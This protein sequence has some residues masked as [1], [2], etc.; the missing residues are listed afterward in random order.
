M[1]VFFY[2][3]KT[4]QQLSSS[5]GEKLFRLQIKDCICFCRNLWKNKSKSQKHYLMFSFFFSSKAIYS[6][7]Y[8]AIYKIIQFNGSEGNFLQVHIRN[9]GQL[10]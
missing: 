5:N 7:E 4:Q 6:L 8:S 9:T 10:V 1:E 3:N 2:F